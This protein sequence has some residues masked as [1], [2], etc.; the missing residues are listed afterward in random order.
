MSQKQAEGAE[1][2]KT[3]LNPKHHELKAVM[4][5][6][7]AWEMPLWYP[8]GAIKEHLAVV[9]AAGLFDTSHMD[10]FFVEGAGS[11]SLLNYAFTRD[12]SVHKPNRALYGIFLNNQGCTIDDAVLYPLNPNRFAV[13]V[14]AG[15]GD[16]LVKHL[17][18]LHQTA[19]IKIFQPAARL[20][21]LDIQG[22]AA[23]AIVRSLFNDPELFADLP[24]FAFKGDF[25]FT[26]SRLKLADGTPVL[27]SRSGYTGEVGFE[28]FAPLDR[29]LP[30]WNAIAEAGTPRGL[31]P[32]GLAARDSLRT[33]AVLPLSHQDIG[34]W[35]FAHNPWLFA[36]PLNAGKDAFTKTFL[37]SKALSAQNSDH[38]HTLPFVGFDQR[39]VDS[40]AGVVLHQGKEI[41]SILTIV[42]D[43]AIGRIDG[44]VVGITDHARPA[45]WT[46]K[47]L[48]CGFIKT[49]QSIATGE[50][51]VLRDTRREIEVE[52]VDDIRPNRTARH[53]L[54]NFPCA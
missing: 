23:P 48:A 26:R 28:L 13:V 9:T 24:Y 20:T 17:S 4:T 2:E 46:P 34:H 47:G 22:P 6:F 45:D 5:V 50:K 29:A 44:A 15:M 30:L 39:R 31:L 37:G 7:G 51:V 53:K 35:Q 16:A 14:N 52:I 43:M 1:P 36:L 41:G 11:Q 38:C 19:G 18:A 25:D 49:S 54:A 21:K 32:C 33:G 8:A 3:A 27:L 40:H 42:S 10:V 12:L